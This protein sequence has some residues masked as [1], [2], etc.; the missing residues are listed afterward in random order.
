VYILLRLILDKIRFVIK[1]ETGIRLSVLL[2]VIMIFGTIGITYFERQANPDLATPA[3]SLWWLIVTM[4]TVGYGDRFPVTTGGRII[5]VIVMLAG[6]G[7]LGTAMAGLTTYLVERRLRKGMGLVPTRYDD[8]IIICGWNETTRGMVDELKQD[9]YEVVIVARLDQAPDMD[10]DFIRGECTQEEILRKARV[11]KARVAI[12]TSDYTDMNADAKSVL[13]TLALKA[14]NPRIRVVSEVFDSRNLP[15]LQRAG[16]D[17]VIQAHEL[18]NK[19]LVRAALLEGITDV[20]AELITNQYGH[21]I[22][23]APAHHRFAG[24][25][26]SAVMRTVKDEYDAVLI[27]LV[28]DGKHVLNP[29]SDLVVQADQELLMISEKRVDWRN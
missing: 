25:T 23:S 3:D 15:H 17:E 28:I 2:I 24:Q 1:R 27:G 14:L 13:I 9:G 26:F 18:S 29:P 6:I 20:F 19:L 12:V 21:E 11:E 4:T 22:Y 10:V 5:A 16:A 7:A 8:H